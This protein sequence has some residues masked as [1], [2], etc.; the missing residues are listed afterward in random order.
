MYLP[1]LPLEALRPSWCEPGEY[2]LIDDDR[3]LTA[4]RE[5]AIAG[6]RS[7]MRRGGVAA[8]APST[9]ML[10]RAPLTEDVAIDAISLALLQFTPEVAHASDM[11]MLMDV[12]AS[13]RL[14]GGYLA[15]CRRVKT[16][17][18]TLGFTLIMASAPT[19]A[20]AWV[21]ARAARFRR[22]RTRRRTIQPGT[23]TKALDRIDCALLP[24]AAIHREWLQN[25]G[26]DTLG[27]LRALPR[28]GL[29]RRTN[30]ALLEELDKA[31]GALPELFEWI[32]PPAT[33]QAKLELLERIEHADAL[34]FGANRLILQLV[35][36]L[37]ALHRAVTRIVL[38]LEHERGR[39][40]IAPTTIEVALAEPTWR[41]EHLIRLLKERLAR[42]ELVAPVIALRLEATQFTDMLPATETLF[43]EPGGSPSD[44]TRLLELLTARLGKEN[45]LSLARKAE[46]R[47]EDANYWVPATDKRAKEDPLQEIAPRPFWLLDNPIELVMR[48]DRPFYGSPL[49]IIDGPERIEAGWWDNRLEARDYYVAQGNDATCYWLFVDR[50]QNPRWYLHGLFG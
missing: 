29:Q 5:A 48:N 7:G 25:I 13:L 9:V 26:C 24:S 35:G 11:C 12:T 18:Q 14:F 47:P 6:V 1:L 17:V 22:Q 21:L 19:A 50:S 28:A 44:F 37:V 23:L 32:V 40:A 30:T 10:D 2:A 34:L 20:G 8:V 41:E 27:Q 49:K 4:S 45:V 15:L 31:Y 36:W 33:F 42:I 3:V 46:H 43:P 16:V 38:S 39:S